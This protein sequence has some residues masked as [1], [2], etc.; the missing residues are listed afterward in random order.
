M[1][2]IALCTW[3]DPSYVDPEP[4]A[5]AAELRVPRAR[6]GGRGL[7]R[8]DVDWASFDLVVIRS[9]W[10]YFDRLDEYLEWA[11]QRG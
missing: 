11:D 5:I 9:T 8:P 6:G 4:P 7:A 10:D 1:S 3:S 2:R